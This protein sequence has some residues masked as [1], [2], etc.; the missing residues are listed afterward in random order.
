MSG[1]QIAESVAQLQDLIAF[2][3]QGNMGP[4]RTSFPSPPRTD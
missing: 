4:I 3:L 1:E 2:S